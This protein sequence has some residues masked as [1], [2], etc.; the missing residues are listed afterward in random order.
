M[1]LIVTTKSVFRREKKGPDAAHRGFA[2][3]SAV[4]ETKAFLNI[5]ITLSYFC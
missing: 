2:I 5:T 3:V 1:K 4:K